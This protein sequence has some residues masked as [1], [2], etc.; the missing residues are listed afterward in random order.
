MLSNTNPNP[1][2]E[3]KNITLRSCK[4]LTPIPKITNIVNLVREKED[5]F[6]DPTLTVVENKVA[7]EEKEPD[8]E[9][10]ILQD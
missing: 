9:Y 5:S 3:C 6:E 4:I 7:G 10:L 1:L 8:P 2:N